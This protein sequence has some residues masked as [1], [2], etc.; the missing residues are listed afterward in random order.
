MASLSREL[1][2]NRLA[3]PFRSSVQV[4]LPELEVRMV[5]GQVNTL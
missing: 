2:E 4:P 3:L 1:L 5:R